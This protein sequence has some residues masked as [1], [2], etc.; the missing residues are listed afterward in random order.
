[1]RLWVV[2]LATQSN[3]REVAARQFEV[4]PS[5]AVKLLRFWQ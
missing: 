2:E 5:F 4:S 1:M 3:S